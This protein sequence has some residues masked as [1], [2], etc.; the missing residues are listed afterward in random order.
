MP[1]FQYLNL[2]KHKGLREA[3]LADLG[4]V[5]VLCGPNNSGKTTVLLRL[6]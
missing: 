6:A 5:N 2:K 3:T 1:H 4:K